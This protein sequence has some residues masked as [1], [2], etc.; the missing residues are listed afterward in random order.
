MRIVAVDWEDW[1]EN[2]YVVAQGTTV[3][4]ARDTKELSQ[5]WDK[6]VEEHSYCSMRVAN[7]HEKY[8]N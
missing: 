3:I 1:D 4:R 6:L 5:K 7:E 2:D 8:H